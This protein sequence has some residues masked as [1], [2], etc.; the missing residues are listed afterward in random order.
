M[1]RHRHE[2]QHAE[3]RERMAELRAKVRGLLNSNL[4]DVGRPPR[5]NVDIVNIT[6]PPTKDGNDPS[7]AL[8]RLKR[9]APALAEGV[10][11][12]DLSANAGAIEAGFR[13]RNVSITLSSAE[14]AAGVDSHQSPN[15]TQDNVST[16]SDGGQG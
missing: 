15:D 7:Y 6:L 9:D 4:K 2:A 3:T 5:S 8:R 13:P 10:L 11:S 1:L 14:S 12:G 16:V